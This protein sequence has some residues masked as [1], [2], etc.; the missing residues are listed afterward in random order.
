MPV[1]AA[2]K[3]WVFL[4][5]ITASAHEAGDTLDVFVDVLAP[6]GVTWLNAAH[7]TQQSGAG[8]ARKEFVVLDASNPGVAAVNVTADAAAGAVRP[9]LF[10]SQF[11]GRRAIADSGDADSSHTFSLVGFGA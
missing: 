8:A 11:R 6:D 5:D 1:S 3:R 10:G 7:F 4:L 2:H 9:A